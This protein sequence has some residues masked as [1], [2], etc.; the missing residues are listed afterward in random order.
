MAVDSIVDVIA[1]LGLMGAGF[2]L[3]LPARNGTAVGVFLA[4]LVVF[5]LAI[6]VA[7]R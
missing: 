1:G 2:A 3:G 5:I 4:G 7:L 6:V